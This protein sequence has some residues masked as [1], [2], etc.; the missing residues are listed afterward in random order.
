[1]K[2][3]CDLLY[4]LAA[5]LGNPDVFNAE[6]VFEHLRHAGAVRFDEHLGY[7][8]AENADLQAAYEAALTER[9]DELR[10]RMASALDDLA[11]AG[12]AHG[13]LFAAGGLAPLG[14]PP[15]RG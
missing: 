4:D 11:N 15:R 14:V 3:R 1:M 5:R 6:L 10:A 9:I 2:T 8:L 12:T 7:A 13:G